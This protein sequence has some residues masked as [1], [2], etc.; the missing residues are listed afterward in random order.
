MPLRDPAARGICDYSR[1]PVR[2]S[3]LM[4]IEI[5]IVIMAMNWRERR[6]IMKNEK[7]NVTIKKKG[8]ENTFGS[9]DAYRIHRFGLS[10][11]KL[12]AFDKDD[13]PHIKAKHSVAGRFFFISF[14]FWY[15]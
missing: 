2:E 12:N 8:K 9:A 4:L 1:P 7:K 5:S 6:K 3:L 15:N 11:G 13:R 14:F 10:E